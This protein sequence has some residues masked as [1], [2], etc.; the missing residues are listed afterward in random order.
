[1]EKLLAT[2]EKSLLE[3][4]KLRDICSVLLDQ[5]IDGKINPN[6][7][8]RYFGCEVKRLNS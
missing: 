6:T 2:F 3:N 7:L 5:I 4:P 1:M 8:E